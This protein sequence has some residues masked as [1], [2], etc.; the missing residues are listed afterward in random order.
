MV[1]L[2]LA[3]SAPEGDQGGDE[4]ARY[5]QSVTNEQAAEG[6]EFY[7]VDALGGAGRLGR[8]ATLFGGGSGQRTYYVATFRRPK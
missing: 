5:L 3:Y 7:R 2:S 6:W 1:H 8:L 4:V